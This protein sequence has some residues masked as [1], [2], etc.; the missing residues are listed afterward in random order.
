LQLAV[1]ALCAGA[2][3]GCVDTK[4]HMPGPICQVTPPAAYTG[5]ATIP[6]ADSATP[7]PY[8]WKNA[9]IKG[10][11]FVTGIIMSPA[12][13][14]LAFARTDVGGGYRYDPAGGRW[15]AI[16]DW[17]GHNDGNLTG[18]ESIAVDPTDPNRVYVAAGQYVTA[19]NG[20]ILSSTD[21]GR[22]WT[23]NNISAPMGGNADGRSMGE[24]LA[25]DPNLPSTLYF[26]SRNAGLWTSTD[27]ART[28]TKVTSFPVT[29]ATN[30]S[31][32]TGYGLTLVLFDASSGT[33]GTATPAI[34]VGVGVNP[35]MSL[36]SSTD[37]GATWNPVANAPATMMPHHAALDGCGNIYFAYNNA[38]GP[39]NVTTGSV[40]KYTTSTGA[41][42]DVS[43]PAPSGGFGGVSVDAANPGTL[44][45]STMDRWQG[46]IFRTTNGGTSWTAI[47]QAGTHDVVGANWLF[48]HASSVQV[49]GW[50][51]D[52]EI[53]PF[54]PSHALYI[55]GQG[56]WSS[57]DVTAADT[58][59]HPTW[60][61]DDSGLEETVAL[62]L[63]SPPSGAPLLTG[64]GDIGGFRHADLTVSPS[65]GMYANP[66]FSNTNAVDFGELSAPLVVARVGTPSGSGARGAY[67]TDGGASW[68]P[69]AA[70][71][72][73]TGSST[74]SSG[75]VAV[76]ADGKTFVWAPSGGRPS[77]STNQGGTW[78]ASNGLS[79]TVRVAADRVNP[80]KFYAA[81]RSTIYV[82]TDG[83][84]NFAAVTPA[85]PSTG[86][87][88]L[89]AAPGVEGDV[90]VTTGGAIIR[91]QDSGATWTQLPSVGA[92]TGVGFGAPQTA[93]GYPAVYVA[94][95]VNGTW[96]VY[97]SD[98]AGA[99][100][101]T[102]NA[103]CPTWTRVDDAQHQFG[104]IN[105]VAGDPRQYGRV[106]LGTGGRGI[107]Y[108]DPA[109]Q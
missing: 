22:T 9:V 24:R 13:Q 84:A 40:Q 41:W 6:T 27:S 61:F 97:R 58:G 50:L 90:W 26:G 106:Y 59:G 37:A 99:C 14:G 60:S 102:G 82:S 20:F 85:P 19:G 10:G 15:W 5:D 56:I 17:A 47:G 100:V 8:L 87:G 108:G 72:A 101:S 107:L 83:G 109:Q 1:L 70:A 91:T 71:P 74:P 86:F 103:V 33:A 42:Q 12:M 89:R 66:I 49:D 80:L 75:T 31:G 79:G 88:R 76:S 29:G 34:Y 55:T 81:G 94:G 73:A 105:C 32:G 38:S 92:T 77:F 51:G 62:D 36:Y 4:H 93:G 11:G 39:N 21:M 48:R 46:E 2:A 69:F 18:I 57:H 43:P 23:R 35:G 104:Y 28:W 25:V 44:L 64:V 95:L 52:V 3:A 96:G 54:D 98:D 7:G 78:T 65:D 30:D 67:S 45:V 16:T 63:I 53:D 68:T